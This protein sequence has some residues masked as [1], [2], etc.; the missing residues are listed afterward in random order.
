[1][2]AG[3]R[4]RERTVAALREHFA[5]GRL[6]LDELSSR[7]EQVLAARSQADLRRALV[8]MPLM[9]DLR[10]LGR[11]AA[12]GALLVLFTGAWFLFTLALVLALLVTLLIHGASAP[13]LVAFLVVWLVPTLLLSRWWQRP[14]RRPSS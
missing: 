12:R 11:S 9:P 6:T 7:T 5:D 4:D 14:L 3:D 13:E 2:V 10:A 8:G 1:M